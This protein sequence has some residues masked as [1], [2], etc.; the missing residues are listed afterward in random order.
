M[1]YLNVYAAHGETWS[2]AGYASYQA[3]EK[4]SFHARAEYLKDSTQFLFHDA[5]DAD[6]NS[7]PGSNPEEILALT[8]TVQYDLW[9]NVIS[10]LELRWDH[11]L[12]GRDAFGGTVPDQPSR[13]NAWLLAA[14]II[15]KF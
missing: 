12:T 6:G 9:K 14:N 15:Y 11:S 13:I 1:D 3:T 10:R 5:V 8:A 4:L 2:V 7:I